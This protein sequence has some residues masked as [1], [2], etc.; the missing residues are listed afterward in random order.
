VWRRLGPVPRRGCLRGSVRGSATS[1][2]ASLGLKPAKG[3][4]DDDPPPPITIQ[5]AGAST[6]LLLIFS[7]STTSS[8]HPLLHLIRFEHDV[9]DFSNDFA[10]CLEAATELKLE[11][12]ELDL[13]ATE[14]AGTLGAQAA[15]G[16]SPSARR[17]G[18]GRR[19]SAS[20]C[21]AASPAP[22]S[23]SPS[24]PWCVCLLHHSQ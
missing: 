5:E 12:V 19:Q 1:N 4:D 6:L 20:P 7:T 3:A 13:E 14:V 17:R 23:S 24:S 9:T 2:P 10:A 18:A 11:R 15:L 8:S 16:S 21:V 22:S